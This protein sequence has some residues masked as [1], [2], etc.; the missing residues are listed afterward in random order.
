MSGQPPDRSGAAAA[1]AFLCDIAKT[2]KDYSF[3][4][5]ASGLGW[6]LNR[7]VGRYPDEPAV[8]P[9]ARVE[10]ELEGH[11]P[12][13]ILELL[14]DRGYDL[15]KLGAMQIRG[16]LQTV[17]KKPANQ[18]LPDFQIPDLQVVM[19]PGRL[20]LRKPHVALHG[21]SGRHDKNE[22][23]PANSGQYCV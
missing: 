14:A 11:A 7:L 17:L 8:P 5:L 12:R 20:E 10:W 9:T 22:A 3:A 6:Q 13:W 19:E 2:A 15:S 1:H 21:V 18:W 23:P 4:G 16:Q